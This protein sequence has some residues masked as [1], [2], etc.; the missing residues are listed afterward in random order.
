MNIKHNFFKDTLFSST[1]VGWNKQFKTE[2]VLTHLRKASL[3]SLGLLQIV[4]A[5]VTLLRE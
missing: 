2:Q 3:S 4:F 5:I 1:I